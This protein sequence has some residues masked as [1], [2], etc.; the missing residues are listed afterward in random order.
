MHLE[1]DFQKI[2]PR[3][4]LFIHHGPEKQPHQGAKGG[5]GVILS[6]E[7]ANYWNNKKS[8][9]LI[10]GTSVGETTRFMSVNIELKKLD[11]TSKKKLDA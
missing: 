7:L 5:V 11:K 1:G 2:L 10:G 6:P 3:K 4:Q 9:L 8:K